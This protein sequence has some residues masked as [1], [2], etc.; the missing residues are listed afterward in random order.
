MFLIAA[1][2][3]GKTLLLYHYRTGDTVYSAG[4]PSDF[5][6]LVRSGQ[7]EGIPA[8]PDKGEVQKFG[9]GDYFGIHALL[10]HGRHA[11]TV[12]AL[13]DSEVIRIDPV[14]LTGF[15]DIRQLDKVLRGP[16]TDRMTK[17]SG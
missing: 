15:I 9:P 10:A 16:L 6:Y 11:Y 12:S 13:T 5:I 3:G 4:E 8:N 17:I 2:F 14:D 7:L 1:A